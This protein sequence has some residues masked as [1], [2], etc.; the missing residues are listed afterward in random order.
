VHAYGSND[1]ELNGNHFLF[2]GTAWRKLENTPSLLYGSMVKYDGSMH[3]LGAGDS[4]SSTDH[5]T[6]LKGYKEV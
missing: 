5:L 4:Y 2:D 1:A 3:Y 6:Y